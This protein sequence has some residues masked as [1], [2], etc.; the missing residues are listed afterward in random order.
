MNTHHSQQGSTTAWV[1]AVL[2]VLIVGAVVWHYTSKN[3]DD[4]MMEGEDHMMIS[5]SPSPSAMMDEG[6]HMM[7][8]TP[9]ATPDA[10][11]H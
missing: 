6:D 7:S 2:A 3:S 5:E 8:P 10:M 1:V 4:A 9:S 11:M